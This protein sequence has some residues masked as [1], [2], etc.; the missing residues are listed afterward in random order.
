MK[1]VAPWKE[2]VRASQDK[3]ITHQFSA[4]SR[5]SESPGGQWS[6]FL[7]GTG[8]SGP[9][10][11]LIKIVY[12][13]RRGENCLWLCWHCRADDTGAGDLQEAEY[14]SESSAQNAD[15][16]E[17]AGMTS[18]EGREGS[19]GTWR[20]TLSLT[21]NLGQTHAWEELECAIMVVLVG[22]SRFT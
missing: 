4:Q 13:K 9:E 2:R 17:V 5:P 12:G 16:G 22:E 3:R 7:T 14:D 15:W 8:S 10:G 6:K 11:L 21:S 1:L 20:K 19:E 18:G